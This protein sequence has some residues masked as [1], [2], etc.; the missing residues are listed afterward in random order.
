MSDT[1]FLVLVFL[2]PGIL[3]LIIGLCNS[4]RRDRQ[5][6]SGTYH[7]EPSNVYYSY[8]YSL[9]GNHGKHR[10]IDRRNHRNDERISRHKSME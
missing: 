8:S 2:V 6:Q 3:A 1:L 7:S 5:R 10:Y 9:T 4:A